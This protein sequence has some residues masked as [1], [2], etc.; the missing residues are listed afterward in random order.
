MALSTIVDR[1]GS[2]TARGF[3]A[4]R[5]LVLDNKKWP[6]GYFLAERSGADAAEGHG[7]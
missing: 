4:A 5:A 3:Q 1:R 2:Q 6:F 7:H